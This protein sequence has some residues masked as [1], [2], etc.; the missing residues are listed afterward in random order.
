MT[1]RQS[2][3][4]KARSDRAVCRIGHRHSFGFFACPICGAD[5][6]S[7]IDWMQAQKRDYPQ[8][9]QKAVARRS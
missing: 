7:F 1:R 3:V 2:D 4:E 6:R 8:A 9:Q 5:K